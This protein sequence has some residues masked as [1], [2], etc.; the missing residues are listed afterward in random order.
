MYREKGSPAGRD[1][2]AG[3]LRHPTLDV[4]DAYFTIASTEPDVTGW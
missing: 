3:L 1:L 4:G 2:P